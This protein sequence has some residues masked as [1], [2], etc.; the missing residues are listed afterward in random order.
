[1]SVSYL[2]RNGYGYLVKESVAS[3]G[4]VYV[5]RSIK[6]LNLVDVSPAEVKSRRVSLRVA[7]FFQIEK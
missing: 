5:N 7:M 2:A 3:E 4:K 6:I 1:M